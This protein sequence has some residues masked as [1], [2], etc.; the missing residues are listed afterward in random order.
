MCERL[1][2]SCASNCKPYTTNKNKKMRFF[3][4]SKLIHEVQVGKSGKGAIRKRSPLLKPRWETTKLTI[5]YLYHEN[6]S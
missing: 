4:N 1:H 5:R 3:K 2:I 6:I